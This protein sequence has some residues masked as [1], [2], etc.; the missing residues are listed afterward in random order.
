MDAFLKFLSV[1]MGMMLH[2]EPLLEAVVVAP[3]LLRKYLWALLACLLVALGTFGVELHNNYDL[4]V[5]L[6]GENLAILATQIGIAVTVSAAIFLLKLQLLPVLGL[7]RSKTPEG[8][9]ESTK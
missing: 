3:L 4:A 9:V 5:W 8:D 2:N 7:G 1:V 6:S